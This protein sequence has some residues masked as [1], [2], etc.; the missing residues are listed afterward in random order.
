MSE[1]VLIV[2]AHPDDEVL[3]VGGTI[4][5]LKKRGYH[6]TTLIVTD[7]SSVQYKG[8]KKIINDKKQEAISA[9]KILGVD[10]LIHWN[11]PDMRLDTIE[12]NKLNNAFEDLINEKNIH[13]VFIQNESDINLDHQL[14][15]KSLIVAARPHPYQ[16][17]KK[18]LSYFVNSSTEWGARSNGSLFNPNVFI[19]ISDTIDLKLRAMESYESEIRKYPHPRS[20]K[21][22]KMRAQVHGLE[23]GLKYAEPFKLV[24]NTEFI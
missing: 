21:G 14:V 13:T 5:L 10:E 20:I 3:G 15:Y 2:A 23:V 1:N 24:L 12:H 6:V 17:V 11:F 8:N 7:G 16:K 9:N 18:I 22:I 19:D 4:P